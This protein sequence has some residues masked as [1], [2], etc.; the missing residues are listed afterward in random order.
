MPPVTQAFDRNSMKSA[1]DLPRYKENPVYLF[2]ESYIL[3]TIGKLSPERYAEIQSLDLKSVFK[4]KSTDW[5]E[6]VVEVLHL[7]DTINIAIKD[8]WFRNRECYDDD[9]YGFQ[10]FAQDFTDHY[11]TDDSKVDIWT[12]GALESAKARIRSAEQRH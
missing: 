6:V 4:T 2:F 3:D 12:D 7:S 10:A 9:K 11:M 1:L 8:L 5:K